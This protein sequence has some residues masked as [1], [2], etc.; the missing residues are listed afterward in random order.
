MWVKAFASTK[1]HI[2][3]LFGNIAPPVGTPPPNDHEAFNALR[4]VKKALLEDYDPS[5]QNNIWYVNEKSNFFET[6]V[7]ARWRCSHA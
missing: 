6:N 1:F 4:C 3:Q 7:T 5:C 2:D